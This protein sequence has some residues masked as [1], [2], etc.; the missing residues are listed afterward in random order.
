MT[1]RERFLCIC[2]GEKPDYIPIFG[3][4]GAAGI[5][6]GVMRPVYDRLLAM[7]MPDVGGAHELDG[8]I[9]NLEGW[10]RF[11]G[12]CGPIGCEFPGK[13]P[14]PIAFEK[15]VEG[16]YE[17]LTYETGALTRQVVNNSVTYSMPEFI[18]FHVRD[19]ESWEYYK[20]RFAPTDPYSPE[21][22]DAL[23]SKFDNRTEP[24]SIHITSTFGVF[25][26]LVG[27]ETAFTLF[28]DDPDLVRDILGWF[29]D[30]ERRFKY[31][32]VKRL[33]PD[34][35]GGWEDM[36]CKHG[37]L[38]SPEMFNDFC[39]PAYREAADVAREAG[40]ALFTVDSDGYTEALLPV[41]EALGVNGLHPWEVKAGNELARVREKH[42]EFILLGGIEK[43]ILNAGN[44][45]LIYP[46]IMGKVPPMIA[47]G[48]YFPNFD[49]GLQ[50]LLDYENMLA[51][52][53]LLH[54]VLENPEG[55]FPRAYI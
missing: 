2:H 25:R 33:K 1:N 31:P 27:P 32:L 4:P 51:A 18:K 47:K 16:E 49:H 7:G 30:N 44:R 42:P 10:C 12:V 14:K 24:L 50:P 52:M 36:C 19:W 20:N 37:M 17:Y 3:I 6:G 46:E 21:Q 55:E 28:Y 11:F 41:L 45:G 43:E 40:V 22:L 53:T 48:R 35:V 23:A 13:E 54:E 9:T 5:S 38:I 15:R 26:N 8:S 39:A 29:H 34:M